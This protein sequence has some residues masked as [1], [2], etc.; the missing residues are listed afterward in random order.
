MQG[1]SNLMVWSLAAP[2]TFK[3]QDR[4]NLWS[5]GKVPSELSAR[6]G[7]NVRE[8]SIIILGTMNKKTNISRGDHFEHP[9]KKETHVTRNTRYMVNPRRYTLKS[10]TGVSSIRVN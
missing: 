4:Q 5:T 8:L 10:P 7:W 3:R 1:R 6:K 9:T 2:S